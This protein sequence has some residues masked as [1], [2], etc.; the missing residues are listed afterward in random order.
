[1]FDE[2]KAF[3]RRLKSQPKILS[4]VDSSQLHPN[5]ITRESYE[6]WRERFLRERL[7]ILYQFA[8]LA[9][10]FFLIVDYLQD[11]HWQSLLLLR[12][13]LEFI[14]VVGLLLLRLQKSFFKPHVLLILMILG[15]N[16]GICH[17]TTMLGGFSSL[18][19]TG[20]LL[21]FLAPAV[22]VPVFWKS[23][24][25][26]QLCSLVY[27]FGINSIQ[28]NTRI[29]LGDVSINFMILMWMC[30]ALTVSVILYERLQ[31]SEFE[32]RHRLL[33]LDRIK[34][35]F[36][37]NI[38]HELRTPLT[39]S[40]GAFKS[41][42]RLALSPDCQDLIQIGLRNGS[43]L[44]FLIN[45]LLALAK[46]DGGRADLQKCCFDFSELVRG[47]AASYQ[48]SK[49]RRIHFR[50]MNKLI[51]IEGDPRQL[52]IVINNLLSNAFKFSDPIEGQVW[53]KLSEENNTL[54]LECEDN[55]IGIPSNQLN[56]I[57]DRFTQV[58]GNSTRRYEGSGIGLAL[59]KEIVNLHGGSISV[60][61]S[62]EEGS[63]F[64]INLPRGSARLE[65]MTTLENEGLYDFPLRQEY[66]QASSPTIETLS[67]SIPNSPLVL[68]A[69]DNSDMR[70]YLQQV[71][72]Q[73]YD[74]C[75][76]NDGEEALKQAR[77]FQPDLI[78]TDVMMP[79]MSG[80]DL[81]KAIRSDPNLSPTPVVFLTARA[82]MEARVESLEAGADDYIPKPFDDEEVL[83]RISN[84]IRA[85]NTEKQLAALQREKLS[86]FL[87]AHISD[88][89]LSGSAEDFLKG[90]RSE[91]TVV[92]IDL[93]G[94]TAFAESAEPEE[95]IGVLREYQSEM[96][97]I[98][99]DHQGTLE[100]F[101]GDGMMVFFND[102]MPVPNHQLQAVRMAVAMRTRI[103]DFHRQWKKR[104]YELGVGIGIATGYA[105]LGVVGF[106]NRTDYAAIGSVTNLA[107]RL[108]S[109]AQ[110]GQ[111]LVP[112]RFLEQTFNIVDSEPVGE[113]NL[114][115]FRNTISLHK[116]VEIREC[117]KFPFQ[118]SPLRH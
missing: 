102:P 115:G 87:P 6:E 92:F 79:R 19:F 7:Q 29:N 116:I 84:L 83:A 105:T 118:R 66:S 95:V 82:G 30:I 71:L 9:N 60:E 47:V 35:E 114:K 108:C 65:D 8:I 41:L 63:V 67:A 61:S 76:T 99:T 38:S 34:S 90:H 51:P 98:I 3:G 2:L 58:E 40:L 72:R 36:F 89:V 25:V 48:S 101:A 43:R 73:R 107:A 31:K 78:L 68:V 12:T 97:R 80:D 56:R 93:R 1:M 10:P 20:L 54:Q 86:K 69:E 5:S 4:T 81:L 17:M 46:F 18:Y 110:H 15:P 113:M 26:A 13:V 91:I 109:E 117:C 53:L 42:K 14:W 77:K 70:H 49:G 23:H 21:I 62:V 33:E 44:L 24:F 55:G 52:K 106:E 28:S 100:R 74:L 22:V 27:Y 16:I 50:G 94:F 57:F 85:R 75:L 112:E 45:E 103:R 11:Q 59:V 64:S 32:A 111:I 39:L 104:G 37:A 88:L 96:G